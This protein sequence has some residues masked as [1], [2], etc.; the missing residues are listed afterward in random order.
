[1]SPF[2]SFAIAADGFPEVW[3]TA[4]CAEIVG[5]RVVEAVESNSFVV[6][7]RLEDY[8]AYF[9]VV[10]GMT[11]RQRIASLGERGVVL[12]PSAGSAMALR[13]VFE[14][15]R[16]RSPKLVAGSYKMPDESMA[17]G[18]RKFINQ[19]GNQHGD[20]SKFRYE[21]GDWIN[22][23]EED[24][25]RKNLYEIADV[26]MDVIGLLQYNGGRPDLA[27][28]VLARMTKVGGLIATGASTVTPVGSGIEVFTIE[29]ERG[30]EVKLSDYF[31]KVEGLEV[32]GV[33]EIAYPGTYDYGPSVIFRKTS[34]R[35][36]APRLTEIK[37]NEDWT[38]PQYWFRWDERHP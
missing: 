21:E 5:A 35:V 28:E 11:I 18:L 32:L 8:N 24:L 3:P 30:S 4:G 26:T 31:R 10:E 20:D 33:N 6:Q 12:D 2:F 38:P 23:T 36:R 1:M 15:L 16:D 22:A 17:P 25:K 29:N 13:D 19:H 9:P 14:D 7:R 37:R 34:S 27:I